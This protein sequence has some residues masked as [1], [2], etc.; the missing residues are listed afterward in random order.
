[1][2]RLKTSPRRTQ[3]APRR[4]TSGVMKFSVPRSSSAPQRPQLETRRASSRTRSTWLA[5]RQ[6]RLG[7]RR[8]GDLFPVVHALEVAAD[9]GLAV[10][11]ELVRHLALHPRDVAHVV[12]LVVAR[13]EAGEHAVVAD[14]VRHP[15]DEPRATLR[16]EVV[17]ARQAEQTLRERVVP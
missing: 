13:F 2:P 6:L 17:G 15:L 11:L 1:R 7:R 10:A 8:G 12:E 16:A 14:P 5:V 4:T 9:E 3:A